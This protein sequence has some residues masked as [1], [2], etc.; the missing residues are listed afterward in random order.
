MLSV[1]R[2]QSSVGGSGPALPYCHPWQL[3]L[4]L[5]LQELSLIFV[6]QRNNVGDHGTVNPV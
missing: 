3:C 2:S 1:T 6:Q 4:Q 5:A